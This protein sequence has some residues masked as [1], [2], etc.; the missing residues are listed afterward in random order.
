MNIYFGKLHAGDIYMTVVVNNDLGLSCKY[1]DHFEIQRL[2]L[3]MNQPEICEFG[4]AMNFDS[5][6]KDFSEFKFKE[7]LG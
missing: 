4:L 3:Q 5:Q 2:R 7:H 1:K 6:V